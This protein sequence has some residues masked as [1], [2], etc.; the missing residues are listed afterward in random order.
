MSSEKQDKAKELE[1]KYSMALSYEAARRRRLLQDVEV[2]I[3]KG[4]EAAGQLLRTVVPFAGGKLLRQLPSPADVVA[5]RCLVIA[6]AGERDAVQVLLEAAAPVYSTELLL[7]LGLFS[8][9]DPS[10]LLR[11]LLTGLV[12][13]RLDRTAHRLSFL[14]T[15]SSQGGGK[16]SSRKRGR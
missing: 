14:D 11:P 16:E 6:G 9:Y 3:T 10:N 15:G 5:E 7:T 2:Y 4:T 8:R 1:W 13:Q 12:Q